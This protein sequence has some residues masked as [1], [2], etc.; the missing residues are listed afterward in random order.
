MCFQEGIGHQP[1]VSAIAI[2]KGVDGN[3]AVV[4]AR[5]ELYPLVVSIGDPIR[6]IGAELGHFAWDLR[7]GNPDVLVASSILASPLPNFVKHSPVQVAGEGLSKQVLLSTPQ[8]LL[9]SA[10]NVG[11]FELVEVG[12]GR[13]GG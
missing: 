6:S 2:G 12:L 3:H 7:P 10:A 4:E 5:P 13:Y 8:N 1:G 11:L 9:G